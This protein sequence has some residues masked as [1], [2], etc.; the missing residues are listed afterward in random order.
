[1]LEAFTVLPNKE[2]K[3][4]YNQGKEVLRLESWTIT[5]VEDFE[6][7]KGETEYQIIPPL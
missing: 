1:M 7:V 5:S 6:G 2:D 3:Y 4:T